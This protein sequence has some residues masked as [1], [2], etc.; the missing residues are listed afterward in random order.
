MS[1][2]VI[3]LTRKYRGGQCFYDIGLAVVAGATTA[4]DRVHDGANVSSANC[5]RLH[6]VSIDGATTFT[7]RI[8]VCTP[9]RTSAASVADS[10]TDPVAP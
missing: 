4:T 1:L 9:T 7:T 2:L 3:S 6:T 5:Q 8:R 10:T